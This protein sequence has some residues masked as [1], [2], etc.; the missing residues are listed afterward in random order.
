MLMPV[1]GVSQGVQ[2]ILGFNYGAQRL[3]RV[4]EAF[5]LVAKVATLLCVVGTVAVQLAAPWLVRAFT[6][7]AGL[8][9]LAT[10]ALRRMTLAFPVIGMPIMASTY[11]QSVG[12]PRMSIV[13]TLMRQAV[14]LIP[15][16]LLLPRW[17]GLSSIWFAMPISDLLNAL[18]VWAIIL[19]EMRRLA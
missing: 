6:R 5:W 7:D 3:D 17:F 8:V 9:A 15:L 18:V 19:R 11:Y 16:L 2:P 10:S 4:R 12:R 1:F 13:L 14:I